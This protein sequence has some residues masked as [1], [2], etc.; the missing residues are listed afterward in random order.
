M[1]TFSNNGD[2]IE[3]KFTSIHKLHNDIYKVRENAVYLEDLQ[4]RNIVMLGDEAHHLNADTKKKQ[5][6]QIEVSLEYT[7][8][9]TEKAGQEAIEKSWENTVINKILCK[10]HKDTFENKN[11]LLE[12]TAT[13]PE[14]EE[15][16]KKYLNKTIFSFDL[17]EFLKAGYTKE[18][19]LISSSF[20]RKERILQALLLNWYRYRI[21]TE[22][23]IPN[24]KG[25]ILFRSK[26]IVSSK[27]DFE[28]FKSIIEG[29][30][31]SDFDFLK[32]IDNELVE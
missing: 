29:L 9:L 23:G 22:N 19:N 10:D 25:V 7:E 27:A 1:E 6:N 30:S 31:V 32:R 15:V 16:Q 24:F 11:V 21:A 13:V 12:F 4:K 8:E 20:D 26:D 14:D 3:I 18:I 17:K 5:S 2:D 28:A